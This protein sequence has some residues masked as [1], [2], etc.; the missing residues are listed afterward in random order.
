LGDG[1]PKLGV[2]VDLRGDLYNS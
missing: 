2:P 1:S